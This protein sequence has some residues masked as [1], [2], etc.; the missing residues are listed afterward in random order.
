MENSPIYDG[1][2]GYG[3]LFY[4]S[5]EFGLLFNKIVE[6]INKIFPPQFGKF[7][8]SIFPIFYDGKLKINQCHF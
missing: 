1:K 4:I 2:I 7:L 6:N 8:K 3:K 5:M